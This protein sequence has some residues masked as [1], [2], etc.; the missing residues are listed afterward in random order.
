MRKSI[1]VAAVIAAACSSVALASE[2]KKDKVKAPA[3]KAQTMS[4]ADMD[5][6]TAAGAP[7]PDLRGLGLLTADA[8]GVIGIVGKVNA[9]GAAHGIGTGNKP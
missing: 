7:S 6:V 9:Q 5:K 4:D 1:F 8:A 3:V 2:V